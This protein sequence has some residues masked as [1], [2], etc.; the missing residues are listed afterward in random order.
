KSWLSHPAVD[1]TAAILPWGAPADVPKMSPVEASA[2]LLHHMRQSW[3]FTN[4][5][6]PLE[7]QEVVIT[8]PASFD[9]IARALT[10]NAARQAG[11]VKFTLVED[12]QAAFYDFTA[13]HRQDLGRQLEGVNLVLVID[14]GGG[15]SDFTLVQV[16]KDQT[17]R[18]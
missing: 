11:L 17:L 5:E 10:V 6:A 4:P 15:T 14:V 3:N 9:E 7:Q 13:R 16:G 1:R 12:P 2:R 8:V 18:R